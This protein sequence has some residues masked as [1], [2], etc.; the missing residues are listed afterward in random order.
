MTREETISECYA[1]ELRAYYFN[2]GKK[3]FTTLLKEKLETVIENL[4]E[5]VEVQDYKK[6]LTILL[7]HFVE[8]EDW[9]ICC[10]I[11]DH[12]NSIK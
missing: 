12:I 1:R 2:K 10:I 4:D 3:A 6:A 9:N 7:E 5:D 8:W 11:R